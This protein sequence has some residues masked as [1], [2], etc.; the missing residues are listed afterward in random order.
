MINLEDKELIASLDP[1]N[2]LGSTEQLIKQCEHA[3]KEVFEVSL[4]TLENFSPENIVFCGMGASMYGAIVLKSLLG[5]DL[6]V[7]IEIISDYHLPS[8]VSDKS[9]VVL[10]SYSGTTEETVSCGKDALAQGAKI[11]VIS[12]GGTLEEMANEHDLT[13]YI[14]DG[15]LNPAGIPRLGNGYTIVGLLALLSRLSFLPIDEKELKDAL[16]RMHDK[17]PFLKEN[18]KQHATELEG[19][20]PVIIAAEHLFGNA[21]ILRNQF[22]E[23]S[24]TFATSFPIPD[25]NHHLME[26]LSFP[27]GAPLHF[28]MLTSEN[29]SPKTLRRFELTEDVVKQ[30]NYPVLQ[31][32]TSAQTVYDD[33]LE[34]MIYGSFLTLYLGLI[35][36]QNPAV[37][38]WVDYFKEN[39][40]S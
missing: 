18:A 2:T 31:F 33:F 1:K 30:N 11:I 27:K 8:Y 39:L 34:M 20:I 16:M 22:N 9:L 4:K 32:Q 38:P 12:K 6:P 25:L 5:R 10:T 15:K 23:T 7:P 28:L 21:H 3:Y 13:K 36:E 29:Y 17:L 14:F 24:K 35:H 40:S 19:K 26:G 37:N